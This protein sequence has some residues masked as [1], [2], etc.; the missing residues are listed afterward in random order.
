MNEVNRILELYNLSAKECKKVSK[1]Y[2]TKKWYII[3]KNN[4]KYF[5]KEITKQTDERLN[6]ILAIQSRLYP[7]TPKIIKSNFNDLYVKYDE[8]RYYLTEYVENIEFDAYKDLENIGKFLGV[9]HQK[10]S[11]IKNIHTKYLKIEDNY[12]ILNEYLKYHKE[13]NNLEYVKII[14][15]KLTILKELKI[16]NI[17]LDNLT[18]Q[19][20]HGDFYIDNI[21]HSGSTYKIIDFDQCCEFYKE[22]ELLRGIFMICNSGRKF[23]KA[24]KK[25]II[26]FV[27]GYYKVDKV[28]SS[29]DAYNF[30]LYIQANSLSSIRPNDCTNIDKIHF[31]RKR[32]NILK[33]L[34][35]NREDI[36]KIL[37]GEAL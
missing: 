25:Y 6:D 24:E 13:H 10:M 15:Y 31:A 9:L 11:S 36:C 28:K 23:T 19:I 29:E 16:S 21:L 26:Q 8:K 22:Y 2:S 27:N 37:K 35:K 30:Y 3:D 32:H 34:I 18:K 17:N 7:L 1:G 14:K 33:S 12:E 5:L 4:N 20:I